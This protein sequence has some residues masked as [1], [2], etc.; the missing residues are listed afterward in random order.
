[1]PAKEPSAARPAATAM[2]SLPPEIGAAYL[3]AEGCLADLLTELGPSAVALDERLVVTPAPPVVAAWAANIWRQPRLLDVASISEAAQTLRAI[4][5]NWAL[6]PL[7]HH[8]RATLIQEKLPHVGAKPLVF[9]AA[10]PAAPLGSWCLLDAHRLLASGDCS[11]PFTNGVAQFIEDKINP[12]NRAYLKLWEALCLAGRW[13]Q[14]G[15]RCLDLGAS[16][17]GWSWVAARLGARVI[18]VDKAPLA[19]AIAAM[20]EIDYRPMSAFALEPAAVGPIDWLFCDVICYPTRLLKLIE[21]W[22]A[23]GLARNFICTL[24]F[25]GAT[26]HAT[27]ARFAAIPGARLIHLHHNK[28]ELTWMKLA[29]GA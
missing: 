8:R 6:Y 9:P 10:A 4:Q 5:R 24:K 22:M 25:Q 20:A 18:A 1:M 14:P 29:P 21:R 28:H 2:A 11:S 26:D 19:P 13:P 7:G 16:P 12:P 27:A 15:E 17:G 3:A 23:S